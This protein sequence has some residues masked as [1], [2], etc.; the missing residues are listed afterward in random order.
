MSNK[1]HQFPSANH[2]GAEARIQ[3]IDC[4]E[5]FSRRM[6]DPAFEGKLESISL[7]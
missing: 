7:G 2:S 3:E 1:H 4:S 6:G 5:W